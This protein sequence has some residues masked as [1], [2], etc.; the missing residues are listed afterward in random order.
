MRKGEG[1]KRK[2]LNFIVF[3]V[4]IVILESTESSFD[5]N[6][7]WSSLGRCL[8][9]R[10]GGAKCEIFQI[11]RIWCQNR[12]VF[13]CAESNCVEIFFWSPF[14]GGGGERFKL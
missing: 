4:E 12:V 13:G 2:F 7:T 10:E 14:E 5:R 11:N 1:R 6:F 3:G 9:N 8:G